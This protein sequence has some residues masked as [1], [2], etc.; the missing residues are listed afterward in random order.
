MTDATANGVRAS[1]LTCTLEDGGLMGSFVLLASLG[2]RKS[3]LVACGLKPGQSFQAEW[4]MRHGAVT[5]AKVTGTGAPR[6]DACA[7]E[8]MRKLKQAFTGRCS[9][10]MGIDR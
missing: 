10:T 5:A 7:T 2:D 6:T 8:A 9:A 1:S 3:A 4:T